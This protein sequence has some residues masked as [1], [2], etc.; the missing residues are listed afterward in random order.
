MLRE[1]FNRWLLAVTT[2]REML[3]WAPSEQTHEPIPLPRG[4][5]VFTG[6][7]WVRDAAGESWRLFKQFKDAPLLFSPRTQQVRHVTLK[8][9]TVRSLAAVAGPYGGDVLA[10]VR[11]THEVDLLD[12]FS[13]TLIACKFSQGSKALQIPVPGSRTLLGV[14]DGAMITVWDTSGPRPRWVSKCPSRTGSR[15][16]GVRVQ[17]GSLA[18]VASSDEGILLH[19][20]EPA[21]TRPDEFGIS[22]TTPGMATVNTADGRELVAVSTPKMVALL[23]P[24]SHQPLFRLKIRDRPGFM[25]VVPGQADIPTLV[26][27]QHGRVCQWEPTYDTVQDIADNVHYRASVAVRLPNGQTCLVLAH[28]RGVNTLSLESKQFAALSKSFSFSV[29]HL[30]ALPSSAGQCLVAGLGQGKVTVW[31]LVT[32]QIVQEAALM[33]RTAAVRDVCLLSLPLTP[34]AV[35]VAT[36][37]RVT[38]WDPGSW[39]CLH[40]FEVPSTYDMIPLARGTGASLLVTATATGL[41]L[42]EPLTGRLAHSLVTAAPV[43][44]VVHTSAAGQQLHIGGPAGLAALTWSP[45]AQLG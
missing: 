23:D 13:G 19:E 34:S 37:T 22:V 1:G 16:A 25:E 31:D 27:G 36:S 4:R 14:R 20:I 8:P 2:S 21:S 44:S 32:R 29:T 35:A 39:A 42:W 15:A 18:L 17:D 11:R 10:V 38:V 41:R 3:A 9:T 6:G 43:T 30:L 7:C 28:A 12:P 24:V 45:T 33:P 5:I 40:E 26:F